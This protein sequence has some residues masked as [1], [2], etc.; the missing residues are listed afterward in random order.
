MPDARGG[1]WQGRKVV[2]MQR[3][4][5]LADLMDGAGAE[6]L[7]MLS[8]VDRAMVMAGARTVR[9]ARAAALA[10]L[11]E[12][13]RLVLIKAQGAVP[14]DCG[15]APVAPARGPVRVVNLM[16]DY[17]AKDGRTVQKPGGFAGRRTMQRADV[18]DVMRAQ[19]A[20]RGGAFPLTDAQ[21]G[22]GRLYA[23]LVEKHEAGG[24]RCISAEA[25]LTA[26]TTGG[27]AEGYTDARLDLAGR[28]ARLRLRIG[29]GVALAVRRIRPSERAGGAVRAII[30]DRALVDL[31][32]LQ[33]MDLSRVLQAHGWA[34]DD[35]TRKA[36]AQALSGAL[37]RM[38]GTGPF[39]PQVMR[40][41]DFAFPVFERK[42]GD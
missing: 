42:K 36:L 25:F 16:A 2:A 19:A 11:P 6:A 41:D 18:F 28:I 33:G 32:C 10:A 38:L 30:T 24:Q 29:S 17:P 1:P 40:C 37:D 35:K 39:R 7:A 23:V 21:V 13:A 4:D 26:G 8:G 34:A 27:T 15:D 14:A 22:M 20:R 9:E 3:D 12:S 5:R 31:V